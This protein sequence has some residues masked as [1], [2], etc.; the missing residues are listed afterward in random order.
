MGLYFEEQIVGGAV[1]NEYIPAVEE[2]FRQAA[3]RGRRWPFPF[4]DIHCTL[5]DGKHHEVD[6]SYLA[7]QLA[8]QEA[9][10]EAVRRAGVVLLEPIMRVHIFAPAEYLGDLQRDLAR[11]RGVIL[12]T[13]LERDRTHV[14][15]HIPLAHLFGYASD[16]RNFTSG[17]ATF[18]MEPSHYAA[19]SQE[20]ADLRVVL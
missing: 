12:H 3:Q 13:Q 17:T 18:T 9:F 16:L 4:V 11:R 5:L 19:V 10:A 1:P 6:S 7:F 8:A 15:A 2:G 20:L 14:Q